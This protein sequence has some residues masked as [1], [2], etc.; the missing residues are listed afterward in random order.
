MPA[1]DTIAIPKWLW[2]L[3]TSF[4]LWALHQSVRLEGVA[5][6]QAQILSRIERLETNQWELRGGERKT[7]TAVAR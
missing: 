4:A 6:G 3:I 5:A 2:G 7:L 1:R